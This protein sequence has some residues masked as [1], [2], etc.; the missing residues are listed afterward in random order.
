MKAE[1][2]QRPGPPGAWLLQTG[3]KRT[4]MP[5]TA[6]APRPD[7]LGHAG[8][9]FRCYALPELRRRLVQ[10]LGGGDEL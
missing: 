6:T 5:R 7:R 3:D 10:G 8:G 4:Q 1:D 9:L 2:V